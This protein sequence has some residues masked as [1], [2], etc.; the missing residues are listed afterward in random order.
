MNDGISC[1]E[2][3]FN[4]L[5]NAISYRPNSQQNVSTNYPT[6][7]QHIADDMNV[8]IRHMKNLVDKITLDKDAV[9]DLSYLANL[10]LLLNLSHIS[11]TNFMEALLKLQ[12]TTRT[13]ER[14]GLSIRILS[15]EISTTI[16]RVKH[17][18]TDINNAI[19]VNSPQDTD[20]GINSLSIL[21]TDINSIED[22]APSK[23]IHKYNKLS[24]I[25]H[26][27]LKSIGVYD[28]CPS[29]TQLDAIS[30]HGIG[31]LP[32]SALILL[33]D[34]LSKGYKMEIS[35]RKE[36]RTNYDY[37]DTP[38]SKEEMENEINNLR[39]EC[40]RLEDQVNAVISEDTELS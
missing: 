24:Q 33:A 40:Q 1:S 6:V 19:T 39:E 18:V 13:I 17:R 23:K 11:Y 35:L 37:P 27:E 4:V 28:L 12:D 29:E 9:D 5:Y 3:D 7:L 14:N 8:D 2:D 16:D 22:M 15:R 34:K 30:P 26:N 36:L 20:L 38:M 10:A 32:H 25:L 21:L 31:P